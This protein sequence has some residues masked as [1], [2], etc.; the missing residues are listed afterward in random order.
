MFSSSAPRKRRTGSRKMYVRTEKRSV[1]AIPPQSAKDET[2]LTSPS[3]FEPS[4]REMRLPPPRPKRFPSAVSRL[5]YGLTSETPADMA[6][7][8][9]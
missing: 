6:G 9:S 2:Y 7:L 3:S 8:A 5:K 1:A 4:M